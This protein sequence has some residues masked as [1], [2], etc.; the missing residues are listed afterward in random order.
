MS[1]IRDYRLAANLTEEELA[2]LSNVTRSYISKLQ[3]YVYPNPSIEVLAVLADRGFCSVG[4]IMDSYRH[5]YQRLQSERFTPVPNSLFWD[6]VKQAVGKIN[7]TIHP[8][9]VLRI[10]VADYFDLEKSQI[11]WAEY[12][13]VHPAILSKYELGKTKVMPQSIRRALIDVVHV[14]VEIV[15]DLYKLVANS[16]GKND[17]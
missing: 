13:G 1:T 17:D 10:L 11:K 5:E 16:A 12:T 14:P 9:A 15:N 4:E 3:N 2:T 8:H 7:I 6:D